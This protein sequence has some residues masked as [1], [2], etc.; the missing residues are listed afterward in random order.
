MKRASFA[1]FLSKVFG[2][3]VLIPVLL[4]WL[5]FTTGT[6][7]TLSSLLLLILLLLLCWLLPV[8]FFAFS[9]KKGWIDD[10]DSSKREQRLAT[11]TL[12]GIGWTAGLILSSFLAQ[13][14]FIRY[15][16]I[17]YLLILFLVLITFVWKISVHAGLNTISYLLLNQVYSWRFWWLIFIPVL[18]MWSRFEKKKHTFWQLVAGASLATLIWLIFKPF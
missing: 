9:L 2:P 10:I 11:Y 8:A 14:L 12:G 16:L 3:P 17:L 15:Y 5:T 7:F 13:S 4:V 1:E 18:V 6:P